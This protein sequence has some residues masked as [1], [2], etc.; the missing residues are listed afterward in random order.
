[1]LLESLS[2]LII[3]FDF[4]VSKIVNS[5]KINPDTV[6]PMVGMAWELLSK[7][8]FKLPLCSNN[9]IIESTIKLIRISYR[10]GLL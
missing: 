4:R 1:L 8:K 9:K 5:V 3:E 10:S 6:I 2:L 7:Y